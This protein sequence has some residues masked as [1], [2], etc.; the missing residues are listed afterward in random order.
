[1]GCIG[2]LVLLNM[3][4]GPSALLWVGAVIGLAAL[5]FAS[6]RL[7]NHHASTSLDSKLFRHRRSI[8]IGCLLFASANTLTTYGDYN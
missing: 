3:T 1:M 6:S 7:G 8:L 2:A 4:S 5:G